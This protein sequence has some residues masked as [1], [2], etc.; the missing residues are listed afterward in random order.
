MYDKYTYSNVG[1]KVAFLLLY[2]FIGQEFMVNERIS[3]DE[4]EDF[5]QQG[6]ELN[7]KLSKERLKSSSTNCNKEIDELELEL[8]NYEQ[9]LK[10]YI[11]KA[12][13]K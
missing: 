6:M 8:K 9:Q 2:I 13:D 4:M 7:E 1:T 12:A 11:E 5:I 3:Y 10:F